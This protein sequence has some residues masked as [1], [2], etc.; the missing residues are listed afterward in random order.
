MSKKAL[1]NSDV[2]K[3]AKLAQL[4][5]SDEELDGYR[6]QLDESLR[7]VENLNE[8][9]IKELDRTLNISRLENIDREDVADSKRALS[10]NSALQNASNK[11]R[12]YFFVQRILK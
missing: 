5:L 7:Y 2:V 9:S 4:S 1:N 6:K 11:K 10:Q 12:H 8:L 3:L